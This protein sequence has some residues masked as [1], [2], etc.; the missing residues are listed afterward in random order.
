MQQ[1]TLKYIN[2]KLDEANIPYQ[3]GVYASDISSLNYYF[4]GDYTET[5]PMNE[6]GLTESQFILT[7]TGKAFGELESAKDT[8]RNLFPES[9]GDVAILDNGSA[10]AIFYASAM[11][12]PTGDERLKRIQINLKIKEWKV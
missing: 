11:Y 6:D 2:D 3:F 9:I 5:E 7:G 8:I 12:I 10:I 1:K 4:V